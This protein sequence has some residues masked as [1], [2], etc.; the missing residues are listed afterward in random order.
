MRAAGGALAAVLAVSLVLAGCDPQPPDDLPTP[1]ADEPAIT[2]ADA[3]DMVVALA[4]EAE[5]ALAASTPA[6]LIANTAARRT[7]SWDCSSSPSATGD[8]VQWAAGRQWDVESGEATADM[9]G[10]LMDHFVD[11]GWEVAKDETDG[12]R[13]VRLVFDGYKLEMSGEQAARSGQATQIGVTAV[14][15]C[16]A[17]SGSD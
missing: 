2:S 17:T 3:R 7:R 11:Q 10:P 16:L 15:P 4:D 5:E 14:S 13:F 1:S 6:E 8:A 12:R 9:L